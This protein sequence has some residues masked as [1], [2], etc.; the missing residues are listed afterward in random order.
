MYTQQLRAIEMLS[1]PTIR[2][3]VLYAGQMQQILGFSVTTAGY[4]SFASRGNMNT[5]EFI[6]WVRTTSGGTL[7]IWRSETTAHQRKNK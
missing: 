7:G 3:G 2:E 1:I 5:R 4:G 6:G